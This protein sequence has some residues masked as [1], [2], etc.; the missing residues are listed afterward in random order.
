M[1]ARLAPAEAEWCVENFQFNNLFDNSKA[2][3]QLGFRY[4]IPYR[5]GVRRC[6]A[7]LDA[8]GGIEDCGKH[9]FYDGVL[10]RWAN[11]LAGL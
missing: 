2:K 8:T 6:L 1:L 3:E 4:T 5:E 9:P 7:H 10:E 11:A